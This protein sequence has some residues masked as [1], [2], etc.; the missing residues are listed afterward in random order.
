MGGMRKLRH[1]GDKELA[2]DHT[3]SIIILI[4]QGVSVIIK[5]YNLKIPLHNAKYQKKSF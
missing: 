3:S 4:S 5:T 2:C 1:R